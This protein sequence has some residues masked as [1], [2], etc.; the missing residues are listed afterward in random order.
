MR[1]IVVAC[2]MGLLLWG[3]GAA[4]VLANERWEYDLAYGYTGD[5]PTTSPR[6]CSTAYPKGEEPVWFPRFLERLRQVKGGG[7]RVH[8]RLLFKPVLGRQYLAVAWAT[9]WAYRYEIYA[10]RRVGSGTLAKGIIDVKIPG[11][12][13]KAPSGNWADD[14]GAPMLV[15]GS[16]EGT[17]YGSYRINVFRLG[18][19]VRDIT[20]EGFGR[21]ILV[22]VLHGDSG[23]RI[24]ASDD[25]WG[26]FFAGCGGCGP[27]VPIVLARE[28][29]GYRPACRE[30]RAYY[31]FALQNSKA[32]LEQKA[33]T[34]SYLDNLELRTT[35]ALDMAQVGDV[36]DGRKYFQ[37]ALATATKA[38][39]ED[40]ARG[41][42][43]TYI[44]PTILA[45]Q[46]T[47]SAVFDAAIGHMDAPCPISAIGRTGDHPGA[48]ARSRHFR[49]GDR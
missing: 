27:H 24:V 25:R 17:F 43:V 46:K 38:M 31:D 45:A 6:C 13:F 14:D 10:L 34:L 47:F 3:A 1:R 29:G 37:D 42:D 49:F 32:Y 16:G 40:E 20:P 21:P 35:D 8:D 4:A 41:M 28:S 18:K 15:V 30:F 36:Q 39:E 5:A 12:Q 26:N 23:H 44:K 7:H 11:P 9:D 33:S 19:T 2:L 22:Q 48:E